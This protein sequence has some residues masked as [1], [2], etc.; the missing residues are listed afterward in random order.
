MN[1]TYRL[2]SL[3]ALR[4]IAALGVVL[5]HFTS[6]FAIKFNYPELSA[7]FPSPSSHI[8]RYGVELFFIISGFVISMSIENSNNVYRFFVSRFSR[9]FPTFWAAVFIS[10]I[11]IW[12]FNGQFDLV[13]FLKN[14][15]MTPNFF[16]AKNIDG[17]YWTLTYE[18]FFYIAIATLFYFFKTIPTRL[19]VVI[20]IGVSLLT[21]LVSMFDVYLGYKVKAL[22][23]IP[24]IHLF[25]AG[26]LFYKL[27]NSNNLK[28]THIWIINLVL[29][30][31]VLVQWLLAESDYSR[32]NFTSSIMVTAFFLIM[33]LV[34]KEKL[35]FLSHPI[36]VYLGTI[37]YSL[38]L[39]HQEVGYIFISQLI[40]ITGSYWL[41]MPLSLAGVILIADLMYR[42]IESPSNKI[43]KRY[44]MLFQKNK[45]EKNVR[46]TRNT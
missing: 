42:Y 29:F 36:L 18:L 3:D 34:T 37:S 15:T 28:P 16:G 10:S 23:L 43:V 13:V 17:S 8:G 1:N 27:W 5:Y 32:H 38:Y 19:M 24:H 7:I 35:S 39:I 41:S 46:N 9:L 30:V 22:L 12:I 14:L 4:G 26:F 20:G 11:F 45:V 2:A 40:N 21:I 6:L 31:L 44:L 33:I 25:L